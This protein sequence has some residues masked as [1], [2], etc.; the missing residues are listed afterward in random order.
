MAAPA[1]MAQLVIS[2]FRVRGPSGANDEFIEIY[3]NSGVDHTVAGG[4]TGYGVA[5]SDG[6]ARCVIPNGTVIPNRG[7][8][9]CVNSVA[10]SLASYPAGNGTTATGDATYVTDIPDNAGI[11]VFNTSVAVNFTLANRMDAVGS[12]SEANTTY[13]EGTGYPALTPFSID[14]AFHRDE[15]GKGGSITTMTPCTISA[16]ADTGNNAAD[17]VF[18]DTNGTSAGAGQRLGAPGPQNLSSP[19]GGGGLSITAA[20]LDSCVTQISPPNYVRDFTSDPPNNS[21]FGTSDVR[22]TFTNNTGGN[23]TR[24]RFRVVDLTTFPA[25]SGFADY[26]PRTSSSVVVTVDRPPCGSGTSNVTVQGT[27][28]EQPPSQPNGGGFNSSMSVG[29]ITLG[30]PLA[31]GASVDARLLLGIQQTGSAKLAI[32]AESLPAG[33]GSVY[34]VGSTD[35]GLSIAPTSVTLD[36]A[37]G[38]PDPANAAPINFT[39]VFNQAV[40]DFTSADIGFTGS[41]APGTLTAAITGGPTTFNVAVSGMTGNGTVVASI[42]ANVVEQGNPASTSTDNT[43][44]YAP[45]VTPPSVTIDQ[46]AGQLDPTNASP[47]NFT[48]VFSESVADFATGDVTLGG[49][50]GATTATVTGSG[51][52]YNVAVS[53]MTGPGTVIASIA[54]AVANDA[55]GND[56][57]ASTSTDNTV[58]FDNATP[59]VTI[60]QAA[61]Q[62]DPTNASPINFTVVFSESVA[63]FATGDV[64]LGGT[65]GATTATVSGS[66]TTYNVAVSGM[67]GAGTVIASVGAAAASDAAGNANTA[68]TST[69]NTVDFDGVA[70]TVTIEQAA[71]QSDPATSQ[72]VNFTV[73]FSEPVTGFATGDLTLGGSAGSTTAVVSGG[74]T[75]FNV[76]VSGAIANGTLTASIAAGVATDLVGNPNAAS[77]SVDNSVQL[78]LGQFNQVPVPALSP[79]MLALLAGAVLALTWAFGRGRMVG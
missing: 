38:Q 53:G 9:L 28:L 14:Y 35:G 65:A 66:G 20:S 74:P 43:V 8:Y 2:E 5:A 40:T 70:P 61:G 71:G 6:V 79:W 50:A 48:V 44:T 52:T 56:N 62:I 17:F 26:R 22:L 77:T 32:V 7:H 63:N 39:A 27:T 59:T 69:D 46:A 51:T 37:V 21:T 29:A 30:T 57:T 1:A 60:D 34:L 10:Y 11:A 49:T 75:V 67:T 25:P 76:A 78:Q 42:G 64:T 24:L 13:K 4:G 23:I 15:C 12:T 55:A 68:S 45:D 33:S 18:V 41:T 47:I 3:N 72:P 36:Q 16:P 54:A 31:N 58:N 19:L 73:T